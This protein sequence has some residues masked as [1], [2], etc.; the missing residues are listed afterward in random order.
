MFFLEFTLLFCKF[1][2]QIRSLI[3]G[4]STLYFASSRFSIT[5]DYNKMAEAHL[6]YYFDSEE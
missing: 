2:A 5:A 1:L 3:S 6:H 4:D